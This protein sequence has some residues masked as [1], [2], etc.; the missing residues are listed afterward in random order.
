MTCLRSQPKRWQTQDLHPDLSDSVS[1]LHLPPPPVSGCMSSFGEGFRDVPARASQPR[2]EMIAFLRKAGVG[3]GAEKNHG[4]TWW[5]TSR[6]VS[7]TGCLIHS[8]EDFLGSGR[9]PRLRAQR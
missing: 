3:F 9:F 7:L 6:S 5:C 8:C 1:Y 4:H 2:K